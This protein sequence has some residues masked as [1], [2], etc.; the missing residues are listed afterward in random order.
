MTREQSAKPFGD[1]KLGNWSSEVTRIAAK[2]DFGF[3]NNG[4]LRTDMPKGN[5]T[6]GLIYQIMPFD[7]TIITVK[8]NGAQVK[9]LLEQ[10]VKENGK[11]IQIAGLS[12]RYDMTKPEMQRVFD[13][14]KSDGTQLDLTSIYSVATN[15]FVGTG[16]DGFLVFTDP[17]VAKTYSD[18]YK[19]VRDAF[20]DAVK[21]DGK[22]SFSIDNRIAPG[23]LQ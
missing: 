12:F 16:G 19:L 15:N 23:N 11:G 2:A 1:S 22:I 18:T 7:N 6:V 4:G 3:G 10:A 21:K 5:I 13:M 17:E 9:T 20:I 14:K 8:M